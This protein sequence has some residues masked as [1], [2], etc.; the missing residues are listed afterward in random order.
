MPRS[1]VPIWFEAGAV[2]IPP[3]PQ[4]HKVAQGPKA[5]DSTSGSLTPD[6]HPE[7]KGQQEHG[8]HHSIVSDAPVKGSRPHL[9]TPDA[10]SVADTPADD[11]LIVGPPD[12]SDVPACLVPKPCATPAT[13]G[14][15]PQPVEGAS[16]PETP[17]PAE[18]LE[19]VQP[20]T[21]FRWPQGHLF[22]L[23]HTVTG[24]LAGSA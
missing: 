24:V 12:P 8:E 16:P 18:L 23:P 6:Q 9:P 2:P 7:S 13:G 21:P 14:G 1:L 5:G 15:F 11:E 19:L 10:P 22:A 20:T 4:A 3:S 17:V